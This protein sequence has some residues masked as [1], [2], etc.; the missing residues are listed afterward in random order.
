MKKTSQYLLILALFSLVVNLPI[1]AQERSLKFGVYSAPSI[2]W[3]KSQTS[4][5]EVVSNSVSLNY[6]LITDFQL[7]GNDKYYLSTGINLQNYKYQLSYP[8]AS[9]TSA[10]IIVN[11][12]IAQ[13][14]NLSYLEVPIGL[15][16]RSDEIGYSHLAGWFGFGTGFRLNSGYQQTEKFTEAGSEKELVANE[17][18]ANSFTKGSKLNIKIGGEYERRITGETYFV[19][20]VTFENGLTNI[21][22][23]NMF[24]L[25]ATES[26][27]DLIK[28]NT[29]LSRTGQRIKA[30][31]RSVVIHLGVYF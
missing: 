2:N 9:L 27:A 14:L 3:L 20:G 19:A 10:G 4:G 7:P 6:G 13:E 12:S 15:K 30:L 17:N 29:S 22:E 31:P 5:L 16:L 23:G 18:D 21:L 28:T 1:L 25:N 24:V 26:A 11:S 8:G